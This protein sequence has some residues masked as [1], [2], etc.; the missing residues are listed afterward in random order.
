MAL[1]QAW[2]EPAGIM[3]F[4]RGLPEVRVAGPDGRWPGTTRPEVLSWLR[5]GG[6]A[7]L[8]LWAR[9]ALMDEPGWWDRGDWVRVTAVDVP[10]DV[11]ADIDGINDED[12]ARVTS[13]AIATWVM[14]ATPTMAEVRDSTQAGPKIGQRRRDIDRTVKIVELRRLARATAEARGDGVP[15]REHSHQWVVRGHWRQQAHGPGRTQRTTM[16]ISPYVKGPAG[17]PFLPTETVFA[18]R[19]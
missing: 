9:R 2:P 19:R 1:A 5:L 14:M 4:D 7:R 12:A 6:V 10:A 17:T 15:R 13:L 18:W 3:L 16:W 11:P 8:S